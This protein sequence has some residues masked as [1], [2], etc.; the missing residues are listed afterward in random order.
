MKVSLTKRTRR[1]GKKSRNYHMRFIDPVTGKRRTRTTHTD[2]KTT[3]RKI[4]DKME[5]RL[6][7]QAAG[8]H[9]PNEELRLA[10]FE[11][12]KEAFIASKRARNRPETASTYG[13]S[14]ASFA[15]AVKPKTVRDITCAAIERFVAKRSE[16]VGAETVNRDLRH[17]KTFLRWCVDLGYLEKVPKI[18]MLR[19]DRRLPVRIPQD[20]QAK[21]VTALDDPELTLKE[22]SR[23]WW[24]MFVRVLFFTGFRR[25]EMLGLI[26]ADVNFQDCWILKRA[27]ES[28]GR[29][30]FPMPISQE[31]A[32]HLKAWWHECGQPGPTEAVF[33]VPHTTIRQVYGEW[34]AICK[35]AG[36]K[37]RWKDARTTAGSE[38]AATEELPVVQR[39]LGHSTPVVTMA[40]YVNSDEAVRS[41]ASKRKVI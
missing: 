3:A 6:A 39:W 29:S 27:S 17:L 15:A 37:V 10:T 12:A 7:K 22:R 35:H 11:E 32:R 40:Y 33:P 16:S 36:V 24:V 8:I 26:W 21:L 25:A 2:R 34:M 20:D 1:R 41:A 30:D 13:R 28:K 38:L 4:A 14:L 31:L 18:T 5:E 19:T 9:D 23:A